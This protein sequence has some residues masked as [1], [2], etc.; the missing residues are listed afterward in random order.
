MLAVL[1]RSRRNREVWDR[2]AAGF[3]DLVN[4]LTD[5][6]WVK[7][8]PCKDWD[9]RRL[10]GHMACTMR[11]PVALAQGIPLGVPAGPDASPVTTPQGDDLFFNTEFFAT[12]QQIVEAMGSDPKGTWVSAYAS[13]R[14]ALDNLDLD[15][16][17]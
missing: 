11:M 1:R 17:A 12:V 14:L 2:A 7:P 3:N 9:I 4:Q 8:T 16:P 5:D 15:A 10:V 6:D 13:Q